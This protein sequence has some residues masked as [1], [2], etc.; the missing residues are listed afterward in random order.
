[1]KTVR[2]N[3]NISIADTYQSTSIF[4][5]LDVEVES[6][7]VLFNK[8]NSVYYDSGLLFSNSETPDNL[9]I[10][11]KG[12]ELKGKNVRLYSRYNIVAPTDDEAK[13]PK[14]SWKPNLEAGDHT[15]YD[16]LEAETSDDNMFEFVVTFSFN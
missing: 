11:N 1:M 8:N 3:I 10:V 5:S 12:S 4:I 14:V 9:K 13:H 7:G 2:K 15:L 6:P 16:E